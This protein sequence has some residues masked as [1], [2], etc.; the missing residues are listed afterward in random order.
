VNDSTQTNSTPDD[1]PISYLALKKETPV[2]TSTGRRIGEVEH[3]LFD[4]SLDLFD[5]IVVKTAEGVRFVD[6]GVVGSIT[7]AAVSTSLTEDEAAALPAPDGSPV[8][9]ADPEEYQGRG[10]SA[11]YGRMFMREHWM[12]DRPDKDR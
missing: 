10:I 3:V 4:E 6:A 11:W 2:L 5:G 9:E 7:E 8:L 1:T 12:R